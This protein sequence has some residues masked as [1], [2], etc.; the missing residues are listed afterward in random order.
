MLTG[1]TKA[2]RTWLATGFVALYATC[3]ITPTVAL[4][5][6]EAPCLVENDRGLSRAH[7]HDSDVAHDHDA[8]H[9]HMGAPESQDEPQSSAPKCCGLVFFSAIAPALD[10]AWAA[11]GQASR[12]SSAIKEDL[13]G[14]P[15]DKLIRPPR[16]QS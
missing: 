5:F 9:N 14:L 10:L 11:P 13:T 6:N 3:I 16:S 2:A 1:L 12:A 7:V 15:P 4:A 8:Q